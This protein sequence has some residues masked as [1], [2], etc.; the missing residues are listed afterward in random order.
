[1]SLVSTPGPE[2][3]PGT[4]G[5][6]C[7]QTCLGCLFRRNLGTGACLEIPEIMWE[8]KCQ[9]ILSEQARNHMDPYKDARL[10]GVA[11]APSW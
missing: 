5:E 3:A 8:K 1:M 9:P 11:D 6:T 7:Q 4:M 2:L 10:K